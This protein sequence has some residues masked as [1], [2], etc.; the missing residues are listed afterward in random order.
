[1]LQRN[2]KKMAQK[3]IGECQRHRRIAVSDSSRSVLWDMTFSNHHGKAGVAKKELVSPKILKPSTSLIS[4]I[5][6]APVHSTRLVN[7]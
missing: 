2:R 6:S 7:V 4:S 3:Y 1:V 5:C